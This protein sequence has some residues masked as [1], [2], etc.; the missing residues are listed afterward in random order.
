[1]PGEGRCS[2]R[3]VKAGA[4][5]Y[6]SGH[7][8]LS[9]SGGGRYISAVSGGLAPPAIMLWGRPPAPLLRGLRT[10]WSDKERHFS[11]RGV[12][13]ERGYAARFQAFDEFLIV[14]AEQLAGHIADNHA[15]PQLA[16]HSEQLLD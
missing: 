13:E 3:I 2:R 1:M 16:G 8:V 4:E 12:A 14:D 15:H 9:R 5:S 7:R 6:G 10:F 11:A